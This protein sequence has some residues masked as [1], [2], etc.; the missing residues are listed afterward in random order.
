MT[1][2]IITM[3]KK[4]IDRLS[5]IKSTIS[6]QL[7]QSEAATRLEL[8]ERQVKRLVRSYREHGAA[9][10]V[11]K[12]RGKRGNNTISDAVREEAI[13]LIKERYSDF[14]PTFAHEK[15]TE[16]HNLKMSVE[17][18][19][20]WMIADG[21]WQTKS[22]KTAHIHQSR[23]RRSRLGELIQIDGS[24][25]D[26]FEGRGPY[27][28]LIVFIDDATSRLMS[29]RFAPAETTQ[30]YMETLGEY[31]AQH[32]RPVALYS[33]KHGIF[34]VN[35][36]GHED[37]LTQFSR[38]LKT[39]D[40]AP[41]HANSPQAKGR[42]ERANQTLQDRLIKEMRLQGINTMEAANQFLP[43]F[44]EDYNRRFAVEPQN[45]HDAHRDV[46]HSEEE[47]ALILC[48]HY[49]RTLSKNLACQFQSC[50]YQLQDF[51]KGHNFRG[52]RITIC[53]G[54]GGS[55]TLVYQ[56]K[57]LSYRKLQKAKKR[58][59]PI[60]VA[61]EKSIQ[62]EVEQAQQKQQQEPAW[63]LPVD[64]PCTNPAS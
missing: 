62:M 10:L 23:P 13:S 40:V 18:L 3:S 34:R 5:I 46:L 55:I 33:D 7:K 30:A 44:I 35:K 41:I 27:C 2:E 17:T 14:K 57:I 9:G 22:R 45:T 37:K 43:V 49:Q 56:G 51:G 26:W 50:E 64:H 20:K 60:P 6:K 63:K 31:L 1:E 15:L 47:L 19:R 59:T 4:E 21:I 29:L 58:V 38:A 48:L 54:F 61:D 36:P 11:S 39:L 24:P 12:R 25:H 53:E 16:C 8:T 32:K 52:A 42:V 28:T